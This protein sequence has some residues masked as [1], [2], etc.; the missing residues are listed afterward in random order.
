MGAWIELPPHPGLSDWAVGRLQAIGPV[1][2]GVKARYPDTLDR[3]WDAGF[4]L[5][6]IARSSHEGYEEP[7]MAEDFRVWQAW[8][9]GL[10]DERR[11]RVIGY[12]P[13]NEPNWRGED[14]ILPAKNAYQWG[15]ALG[16]FFAAV[17]LTGPGHRLP[18]ISPG[19]QPMTP[20]LPGW[21][22]AIERYRDR[23]AWRGVHCYTNVGDVP[24]AIGHCLGQAP[25][26]PAGQLLVL[27]F[28]DSSFEPWE[29]RRDVAR[30]LAAGLAG[31]GTAVQCGFILDAANFPLFAWADAPDAV[32]VWKDVLGAGTTRLGR[33]APV[34]SP[35]PPAPA[36]VPAP[37]TPGGN[38]MDRWQQFP[39]GP[40]IRAAMEA[41]GDRPT[42][43]EWYP[44][45]ADGSE[46]GVAIA[47]GE[48][49]QYV[50]SRVDNQVRT[51]PFR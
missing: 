37:P 7:E 16:K 32:A 34:P 48:R 33:P 46:V 22:E 40:G 5:P 45:N 39:I 41:N 35:V 11:A 38:S 8:Y 4:A 19:L 13:A 9:R 42:S 24:G 31:A 43:V 17:D 27:E 28:G 12:A 30:E 29:R 3:F 10:P 49:A 21:I 26:T 25:G 15:A 44:R 1:L 14:G 18:L 51:A 6:A 47:Y 20:D 36:P 23:W 50:Y 2:D